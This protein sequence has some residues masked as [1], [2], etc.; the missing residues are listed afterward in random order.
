MLISCTSFGS[1][2]ETSSLTDNRD[3]ISISS[4][5]EANLFLS[6]EAPPISELSSLDAWIGD[7]AYSVVAPVNG[8]YTCEISIYYYD[9][10]CFADIIV[11]GH[12]LAF[13]VRGKV[14]GSKDS[15]QIVFEEYLG[16]FDL[17]YEKEEHILTFIKNGQEIYT[18]WYEIISP[19]EGQRENTPDTTFTKLPVV[20]ERIDIAENKLLQTSPS[21]TGKNIAY[22]YSS[23]SAEKNEKLYLLTMLPAHEE[24][25]F[26][27]ANAYAAL[28][29]FTVDWD[30]EGVN[31]NWTD[32]DN[33]NVYGQEFGNEEVFIK[34]MYRRGVSIEYLK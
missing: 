16:G 2:N 3:D 21:P 22:V 34:K 25:V 33:L 5:N 28:K 32:C 12:M 31:T 20:P 13:R 4:P 30:A 24:F 9:G 8:H 26:Q 17:N 27:P 7:Y 10:E 18:E 11:D 1:E 23:Y 15:V 14:S 6:E 29:S 19:F